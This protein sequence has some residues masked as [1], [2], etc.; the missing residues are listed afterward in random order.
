MHLG[1]L[2]MDFP[3]ENKVIVQLISTVNRI[4]NNG[5]VHE[6]RVDFTACFQK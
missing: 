2:D 5:N 1:H 3:L 6:H 4:F